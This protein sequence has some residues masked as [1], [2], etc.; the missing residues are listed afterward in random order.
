VVVMMA[1][2]RMHV[3]WMQMWMSVVVI[4]V[5]VEVRVMVPTL[6]FHFEAYIRDFHANISEAW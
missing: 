1:M 5:R 6:V 4:Q 2:N 3:Q